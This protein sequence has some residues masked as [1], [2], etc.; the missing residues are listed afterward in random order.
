MYCLFDFHKT[1]K[2]LVHLCDEQAN[3]HFLSEMKISSSMSI[4]CY[5]FFNTDE[6][7][8]KCAVV[9]VSLMI[10]FS[11]LKVANLD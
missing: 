1:S 7:E 10:I 6:V 8:Q 11:N 5:I 2:S 9:L 3:L 4:S